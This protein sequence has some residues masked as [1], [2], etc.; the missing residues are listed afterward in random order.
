MNNQAQLID[1]KKIIAN[2]N[3][4]LLK[5]LPDFIIRYI[6]RTIHQDEVNETLA[7][8]ADKF[9]IDFVNAVL[10]DFQITIKTFGEENLPSTGR[11][12]FAANHPL[13]GLESLALINV[14]NKKY[15]EVRFL[16][17]DILLFLKNFDPIFVPINHHGSQS[18]AAVELIDTTYNSNQQVLFFPAGLV[19]RKIKG[20]IVDLEWKKNFISKA[21]KHQRDIIPVFIEGQNSNFFYNLAN[22]RKAIGIKA[23]IEM[24]FLADEMYQQKGKTI[25]IHFGKPI[26]YS[27]FDKSQSPSKWAEM[28]KGIV[29]GMSR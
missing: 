9:G 14:T 7:R 8:H 26:S 6:K 24:F 11:F 5:V 17:N 23:N 25:S 29:Y 15:G 4:R 1:I 3:P 16:V 10:D 27:T 19:S 18:K 22:F 13:G 12:I 20:K 21:T 2:K 28:V